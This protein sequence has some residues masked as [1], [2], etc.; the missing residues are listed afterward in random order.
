AHPAAD[1]RPQL[2]FLYF[3]PLPHGHGSLRPTRGPAERR[4]GS[5]FFPS[6]PLVTMSSCCVLGRRG[7]VSCC[8]AL[9]VPIASWQPSAPSM[10]KIASV[11]RFS[12]PSFIASNS[13]IPCRLYSVFG[14]TWA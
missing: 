13:R 11:T 9:I 10:R 14:S 7:A 6:A 12:T 4:I 5:F 1:L 3:L 8:V 2:Q